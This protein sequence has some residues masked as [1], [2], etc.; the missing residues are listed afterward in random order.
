MLVSQSKAALAPA[1]IS[2]HR[3][4]SGRSNADVP[5]LGDAVAAIERD[6]QA[7]VE[8]AGCSFRIGRE[9]LDDSAGQRLDDAIAS[10]R[11][12]LLIFHDPTMKSSASTTLRK[13]SPSR[14]LA[15][16]TGRDPAPMRL[17]VRRSGTCEGLP[18][19]PVRPR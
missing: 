15:V 5:S 8:L 12:P 13:S 1:R 18:H 11:K 2:R 16:I 9:F 14:S 4:R 7:E 19:L 17:V 6:G 10:M 3:Q